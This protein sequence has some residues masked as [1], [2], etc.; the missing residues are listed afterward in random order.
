MTTGTA[1]HGPL[2]CPRCLAQVA[3][4]E[5]RLV[6]SGCGEIYP[7]VDGIPCFAPT[8][9]FYDDYASEHCPYGLSPA[10][11]KGLILRLLPFWSW[12]EWQ[13]WSRTIP[14]C[15]GAILMLRA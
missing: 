4:D 15:L 7:I 8:D 3:G 1:L 2:A 10:G 6:C 14:R 9:T 13:F 5:A 12:R 11:L